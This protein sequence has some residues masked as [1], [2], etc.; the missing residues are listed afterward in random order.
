VTTP[1][2]PADWDAWEMG[3]NIAKKIINDQYKS[4]GGM[5]ALRLA[6]G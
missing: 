3:M 1:A 5:E 4:S 6:A 2:R